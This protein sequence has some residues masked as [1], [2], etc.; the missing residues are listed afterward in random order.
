[1][2]EGTGAIACDLSNA[3]GFEEKSPRFLAAG[4]WSL[5]S[6]VH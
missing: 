1:M 5:D 4:E 2:N 6:F 3:Q